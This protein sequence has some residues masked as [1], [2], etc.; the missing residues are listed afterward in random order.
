LRIDD[1]GRITFIHAV[2]SIFAASA[3]KDVSVAVD[4][5]EERGADR[6]MMPAMVKAHTKAGKTLPALL[7]RLALLSKNPLS[8]RLITNMKAWANYYG[9]ARQETLILLEF[10][11]MPAR[12]EL[13]SDP[14][15]TAYLTPF[16][17]NR[18]LASVSAENLTT[19]RAL[20]AE[21]GVTVTDGL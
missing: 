21:R 3:V 17:G 13:C 9:D 2:P 8:E 16:A 10:R 5:A 11:D 14:A 1:D 4:P 15:L 20:L 12:D 7:D 19:V 6:R 18:P